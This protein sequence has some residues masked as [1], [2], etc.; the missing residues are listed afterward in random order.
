MNPDLLAHGTDQAV[1]RE[2]TSNG[3][4]TRSPHNLEHLRLDVVPV[5]LSTVLASM[6]PQPRRAMN[7]LD[8]MTRHLCHLAPS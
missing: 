3:H 6:S 1:L 2:A 8:A 5:S 7:I 4:S